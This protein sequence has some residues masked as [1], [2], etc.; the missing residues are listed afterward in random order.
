[1]TRARLDTLLVDRGL[2]RSRDRARALIMAGRVL[3]C[4]TPVTK[5]G[6]PVAVDADLRLRGEDHPF[7]SR[8]GLKLE[9]ALDDLG[10]DVTGRTILDVGSS[11]G[12]FTDC[13]LQRG[14]ARSFCVDVGTNQLD[15]SLR[16]DPRVTVLEQTNA[17]YLEPGHLPG[18]ADLAVID[19]SFISL[20]LLLEPVLRCLAAEGEVLAMIKPQ[21]EVGRGKVGKGGVVRDPAVRE[22]AVGSV[23]AHAAS[24]G[25]VVAGRA[26]SRVQG[27]KGNV[28]VFV[29]F[30]RSGGDDAS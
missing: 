1:M 11:T 29:H 15:W 30:R 14:A 22:D 9:A 4:D 20:T 18:P 16:Q 21:F 10:I 28:E 13:C 26:D 3:V 12:G 5:P 23:V 27:P 2:V 17:R 25:L 7:V 24:L 8:G 19:V 6:T